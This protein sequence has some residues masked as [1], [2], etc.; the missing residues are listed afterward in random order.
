VFDACVLCPAPL[1]DFLIR[2]ATTGLFAAR[3]TD[4]IH[5]EWIR[6]LL[7]NRPD[8]G[9]EKLERTRSLMDKAV[10][11]CLVTEYRPLIASLELPDPDDRHVLAAA[12]RCGA[13]AIVTFNSSDFPREN[14]LLYDVEAIH[15]DDFV[16]NQF[17]LHQ[18]VVVSTA[19]RHRESLRNP[20]K[21]VNEY[22]DTLAAQGLV[23]TAGI[24]RDFEDLI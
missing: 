9:P 11:D 4:T 24:L 20:P 3:W 16:Q 15:P 6:N 12:I 5:E 19:K 17:D 14:L 8:I 18:E 10:P 23:V 21:S 1:R 7:R 13:Q 2:L 22:L